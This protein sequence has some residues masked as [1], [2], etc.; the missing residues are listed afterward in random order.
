MTHAEGLAVDV[1]EREQFQLVRV[2]GTL[3]FDSVELLRGHLDRVLAAGPA[4]LVLDLGQVPFVDSTGLAALLSAHRRAE[5]A[6]GWLRLAD[7]AAQPRRLLRTTN[8]D[9]RFA[10]YRNVAAAAAG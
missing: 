3:D 7:L 2:R 1:E 10:T 4:R 6:G 9:Q 8:L 5:A